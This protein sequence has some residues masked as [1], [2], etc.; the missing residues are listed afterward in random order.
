MATK[1]LFSKRQPGNPKGSRRE[2]QLRTPAPRVLLVCEGEKTEPKYFHELAST[3]GLSPQVQIGKNDGSSP[4]RV[5][6]RAEELQ[7]L[8]RREGDAFDEVYCVFDR[9]AHERFA[10]AVNRLK[11]LAAE[12]QPIKGVVSV[13]CFEFWLLLHFGYTA[14]PYA[15]TGN[16][17]VGN[18]VVSD[19]KTKA[20]FAKYDKGMEGVFAMLASRLTAALKHAKTLAANPVDLSEHPNPSTQI[21]ELIARLQDIAASKRR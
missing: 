6:A 4:D 20:G 2:A 13:P 9:D 5:V 15:R 21:H 8:A 16:K 7:A 17:S 1:D 10:D 19:L 18:V 11:A 3:W 12:G 14:K